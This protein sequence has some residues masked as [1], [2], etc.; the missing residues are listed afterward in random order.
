MEDEELNDDLFNDLTLGD[1]YFENTT[2]FSVDIKGITYNGTFHEYGNGTGGMPGDTTTSIEWEEDNIP[3]LN[4]DEELSL[5]DM[6]TS[7]LQNF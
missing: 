5:T 3:D 1:T 2:Q 4:E 7:D 6:I